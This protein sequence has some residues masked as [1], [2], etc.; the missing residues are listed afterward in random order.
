L[1][2]RNQYSTRVEWAD[3]DPLAQTFYPNYFRWFDMGTHKLLEAVGEPYDD[4]IEKRNIAGLPLVDA[5][6]S[7]RGRCRWTDHIEV[8]SFISSFG[9]KSFTVS[10]NIWNEGAIAVEGREVRIWGLFDPN[11]DTKLM[12]GEIPE[13]FKKL[14]G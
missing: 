8:E 13:D 10:H 9:T 6:A 2:F 12:A 5:Q 11:D 1:P 4:L 7:F 3:S 14:L